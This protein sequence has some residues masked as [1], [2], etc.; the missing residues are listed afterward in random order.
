MW[1]TLNW[2][3]GEIAR[4]TTKAA[5]AETEMERK[6]L[7]MARI[8]PYARVGRKHRAACALHRLHLLFVSNGDCGVEGRPHNPQEDGADQREEI[9]TR[10]RELASGAA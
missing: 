3:S 2:I 6:V 9:A 10:R 1:T 4:E 7:T 5:K 8:C